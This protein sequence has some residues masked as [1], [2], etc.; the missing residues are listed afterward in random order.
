M[1]KLGLMLLVLLHFYMNYNYYSTLQLM[2]LAWARFLL[3]GK[4]ANGN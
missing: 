1:Q 3:K 2:G 4:F